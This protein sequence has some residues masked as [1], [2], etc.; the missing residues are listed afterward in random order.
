MTTVREACVPRPEVLEGDLQDAIFAAEFGHVTAE[1]DNAPAV[2]QNPQDFFRNTHPA[3][4]LQ[5]IVST[6]FE[7]LSSDDEA[8]AV[9]RLSTGF[10]GGK[11][12][13]LI[14][15][16]HLANNLDDP[17]LGTELLPAAASVKVYLQ[18]C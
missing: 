9:I 8:G 14:A 3:R 17:T 15:L 16:W 13:A 5:R 18:S 12:H 1:G 10:G 6:I 11:T 4:A 2:Y 7:H